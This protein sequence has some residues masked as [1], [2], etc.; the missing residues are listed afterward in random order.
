MG[1]DLVLVV[2]V[3]HERVTAFFEQVGP[4]IGWLGW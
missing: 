2:Y 4:R 3:P 1:C